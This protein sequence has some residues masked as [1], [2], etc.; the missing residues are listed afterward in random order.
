MLLDALDV[1]EF[2]VHAAAVRSQSQSA[3]GQSTVCRSGAHARTAAGRAS[4]AGLFDP[5]APW[6]D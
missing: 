2:R 3:S 6:P 4:L 1:G 5:G